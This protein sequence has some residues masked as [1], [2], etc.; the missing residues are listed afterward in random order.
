MTLHLPALSRWIAPL[1]RFMLLAWLTGSALAANEGV[2]YQ[3]LPQPQATENPAQVEV[4]EFFW[5]GC[6]HCFQL[7]PVLSAWVAKKP[8][9]VAFRRVPAI[10]G[11]QWEAHARAY[12]AAELLGVLGLI[13]DPLMEAI[14]VKKQRILTEADLVDFVTGLGVD[15]KKFQE[16]YRSFTVESNVKRAAQMGERLGITGVPTVIINGKYRT[17]PVS[18]GGIDKLMPVIDDLIRKESAPPPAAPQ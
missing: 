10:L 17:S 16:A 4:L 6:P 2:D 8:P 7:E 18:T 3:V 5:Y 12:Y 1:L 14:H 9:Q 11:A 13:H 15:R